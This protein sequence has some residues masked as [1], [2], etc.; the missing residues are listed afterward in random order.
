M[1]K[2][3]R[4]GCYIIFHRQLRQSFGRKLCVLV[5]RAIHVTSF[6]LKRTLA[7]GKLKKGNFIFLPDMLVR[8]FLFNLFKLASYREYGFGG[9]R[10]EIILML[11]FYPHLD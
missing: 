1:N 11:S 10:R 4:D 6:L 7:L 9:A 3:G 5:V 2:G 8:I